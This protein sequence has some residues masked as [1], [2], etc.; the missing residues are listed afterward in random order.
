[1]NL[2]ANADW[3]RIVRGHGLDADGHGPDTATD[4]DKL[5][6][7]TRVPSIALIFPPTSCRLKQSEAVRNGSGKRAVLPPL[8]PL[9][10]GRESFPSSGSSPC[11]APPKRNRCHD[12]Y[13]AMPPLRYRLAAFWLGVH[14][15]ASWSGLSAVPARGRT[16]G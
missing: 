10:T 5:R 9:R 12:G 6:A 4:M 11:K 13:R 14:T 16:H 2:S 15:W 8:A 7:R 1:M 3:T